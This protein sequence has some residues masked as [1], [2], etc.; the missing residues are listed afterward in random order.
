MADN[1]LQM[2]YSLGG[3]KS[4]SDQNVE[5]AYVTP[6]QATGTFIPLGESQMNS[7]CSGAATV[8]VDTSSSSTGDVLNDRIVAELAL[9]FCDSSYDVLHIDPDTY[10]VENRHYKIAESL[11]MTRYGVRD[12]KTGDLMLPTYADD[13]QA[14]ASFSIASLSY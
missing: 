11:I 5:L 10:Q 6:A 1:I 12:R 2:F 8:S 3:Y 14:L 7:M 13:S 9:Y 4:V